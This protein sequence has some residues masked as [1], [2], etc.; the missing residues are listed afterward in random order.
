MKIKGVK[1]KPIGNGLGYCVVGNFFN[2]RVYYFKGYPNL[3]YEDCEIIEMVD[4]DPST[5]QSDTV[6]GEGRDKNHKYFQGR[7]VEKGKGQL[8]N[9]D[10]EYVPRKGIKCEDVELFFNSDR[11]FNRELLGNEESYNYSRSEEEDSYKG[12]Q[13]TVT[14]FRL[15]YDSKNGLSEIE[16][17]GGNLRLNAINIMGDKVNCKQLINEFGSMNYKV[18]RKEDY[19]VN[20]EEKFTFSSSADMGGD[21]DE[22]VYF[23]MGKDID[24]LLDE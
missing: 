3:S 14:W 11:K 8:L 19:W 7:I 23:Y 5:F 9:Q 6:M 24:H 12:F 13:N 1:Y 2:K 21:S 16:F 10:W 15:S 4:A 20:R 22:C 18:E 17:L